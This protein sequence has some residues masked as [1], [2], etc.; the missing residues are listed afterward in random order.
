MLAPGVIAYKINKENFL[1]LVCTFI[2]FIG[3]LVN[4]Y[5]GFKILL[6]IAVDLIFEEA[7]TTVDTSNY[8]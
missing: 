2:T 6:K 5:D 1:S 8:M 7:K 3:F 4:S